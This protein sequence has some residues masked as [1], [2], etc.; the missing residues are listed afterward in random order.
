MKKKIN[1]KLMKIIIEFSFLISLLILIYGLNLFWV[2]F[3]NVDICHNEIVIQNMLSESLRSINKSFII[4]E[5]KV[6]DG[7][8]WSLSDCYLLGLKG[9]IEGFYVSIVGAF[10]L[11][12]TKQGGK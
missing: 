6:F 11:G 1:K 4:Q 8:I 3:H 10:L 9:I 7:S 12:Y 2:G 5:Q